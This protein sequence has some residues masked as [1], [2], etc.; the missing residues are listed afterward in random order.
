MKRS[1][2]KAVLSAVILI[3]LAA[4]ICGLF[5]LKKVTDYKR[6][7]QET[8]FQNI[9]ISTIHDGSYIGEYDAGFVYAKVEVTVRAGKMTAVR[10][11]EHKQERGKA[12]ESIVNEMLDQQKTDVAAVSGA[13]NSSIVIKKA[14]ENA[15]MS[16]Q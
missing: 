6:K 16:G 14:V 4:L 8:V 10:I 2:K 1:G 15:L 5:Y 13:T 12:A 7:V 3:F 11:L 9:D